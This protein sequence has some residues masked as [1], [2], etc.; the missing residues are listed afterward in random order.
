M[1]GQFYKLQIVGLEN[2]IETATSITL[3]VP[4]NLY[5]TF[6][7]YPGQHIVLKLMIDGKE[8]RRSY[9]MNSCPYNDEALQVTVKRV[10]NGLVS[11]YIGDNFRV[12]DSIEV[13][14]PQGRFFANIDPH[15]Y[16]TYFLFA[17]G[18]GITPIFSIL[19][20]V[21]YTS[22]QSTVNLFYGNANQDTIIFYDALADL[23]SKYPDRLNII[24]TLSNP[25]VWTTW[26]QWKGRKG[27]I[28]AES[29]EHFI[30]NH[31]PLAQNTEYY[32]CGPGAMNNTVR[33]TLI[34][35]GVPQDLIHVEQ[36]GALDD[37]SDEEGTIIDNANLTAKLDGKTFRLKIP[38]GKTILQVLKEENADPPYSCESGV[39][40]TC[41]TKIVMGDVSMKVCL[42]L[43]DDEI[44][45]GMILAC[46]ARPLTEHIEIEY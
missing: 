42:A 32:I 28:N 22:P 35:L 43:D 25:K 33:E 19:K 23:E 15:G 7:F 46:Q 6:S 18:S 1:S 27:R 14:V 44:K 29:V 11:N 41:R 16:K 39:C 12:G 10:E 30:T 20:S 5:Q 9:S 4:T 38:K 21:L 2:P 17:A 34:N 45:S 40:G 31:P 36:F 8:V 26:T 3:D 13:M 24:H 37:E